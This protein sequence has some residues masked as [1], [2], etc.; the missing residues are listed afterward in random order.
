M[1]QSCG[2][3]RFGRHEAR[4]MRGYVSCR[5]YPPVV[6]AVTGETTD[7]LINSYTGESGYDADQVFH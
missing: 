4:L 2:N 5:R 6:I 3:C 1:N 7:T